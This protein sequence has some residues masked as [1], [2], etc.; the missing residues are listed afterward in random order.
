L[1]KPG[2]QAVI[3]RLQ[4]LRMLVM[5]CRDGMLKDKKKHRGMRE[6]LDILTDWKARE[7]E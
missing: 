4:R 5:V 3:E 6:L 1:E 7:I 2:N